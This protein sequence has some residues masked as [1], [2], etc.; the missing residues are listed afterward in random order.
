MYN[1]RLFYNVATGEIYRCQTI[2]LGSALPIKEDVAITSAL[3]DVPIEEIGVL[4][5]ANADNELESII[6]AEKSIRVD[7]ATTPHTVY[8]VEPEIFEPTDEDEISG[9]E[10]LSMVEEVL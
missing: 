9:S 3:F 8:G 6:V 4:E 2:T 1:A 5:W 10:F 7:V